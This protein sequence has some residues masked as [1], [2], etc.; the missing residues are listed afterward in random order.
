MNRQAAGPSHGRTGLK[1]QE[2]AGELR[3]AI[4]SGTYSNGS[5]LPG[6]NELAQRFSVSRGTIRRALD[7]LADD[8][9]IDTRTGIGSFVTF[10]GRA[11]GQA[12]SWGRALATSGVDEHPDILRMEHVIDPDLAA[13]VSS[14]GMEF[15]ALDRV[16][17]LADGT[18]VSL[19]RSRVPAAGIIATVPEN[20]LVD[21][22]LSKTLAEAGLVA[23]SGE[24]WIAVAAL[25][26]EDARILGREP[27][28]LFLNS[29]R[30]ARDADGRF[31][32][33]VV[34]WLDPQR[35]RLHM[36]F[37]PGSGAGTG[38]GTGAGR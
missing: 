26:A 22:S 14:S 5:L 17:R 25:S 32:E 18:A 7:S 21:D 30:V 13:A 8:N 29:V 16:R 27:G 34:S 33:K 9:L 6:E 28:E 24:Q 23:E 31:V 12:P 38:A 11:I 1:R 10:D 35:F 4:L 20:G 37:G 2:I 19:E 36:S 3:D 15:L